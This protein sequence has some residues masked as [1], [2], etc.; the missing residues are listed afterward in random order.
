MKCNQI[1]VLAFHLLTDLPI[2]LMPHLSFSRFFGCLRFLPVVAGLS[3]LP[4]QAEEVGNVSTEHVDALAAHPAT[5]EGKA[6]SGVTIPEPSMLGLVGL[7]LLL[8]TSRHRARRF[9]RSGDS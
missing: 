1:G 9:G 5:V 7:T 6:D 8:I 2:P 4:V 3:L